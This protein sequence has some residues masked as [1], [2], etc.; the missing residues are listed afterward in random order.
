MCYEISVPV[1][2]N[3]LSIRDNESSSSEI[4]IMVAD[5]PSTISSIELTSKA[6]KL[7]T[8]QGLEENQHFGY[9]R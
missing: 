7:Y 5:S 4:P 2:E 9:M 3:V 6:V 8:F 1:R